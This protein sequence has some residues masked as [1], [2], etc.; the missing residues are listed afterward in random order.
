V[1][2]LA[3]FFAPW[4]IV[5]VAPLYW[6]L[7]GC[8]LD[9]FT[10]M[11]HCTSHRQLF[12]NA[13]ARLNRIIPWLLGPF[14]GQTPNAYFAHHMGMHHREENLSDDLSSTL[15]FQR[16][17]FDHFLRYWSRFLVFGLVELGV[18]FSRRGQSKLL[19]R[20]IRGEVA[21]WALIILLCAWKPAATFVVFIGP[22]I[23]IRTLMMM[24]NWAQHSFICAD[25]PKDPYRA[26]IT[27]INTRYN[28]RC[29]NDGYHILHHVKPRCHWTEHPIEFERSLD[30]YGRRDAIVFDGL[31]YFQVWLCLMTRRW[32][33]LAR[34]FVVLPGAPSRTQQQIIAFLKDRV[35]AVPLPVVHEQL[36]NVTV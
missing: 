5:Y 24:G 14:F 21:Y 13:H 17:R 12:R 32:A 34:H 9:R 7:M 10:L 11:L 33:T 8:V 25:D 26:S 2:G 4:P 30:E 23:A 29:F 28:R 35:E 31:D 1:I 36:P 16:D 15:R 19:G 22:L 6:L 18:Y 27:C 20:L 3:V